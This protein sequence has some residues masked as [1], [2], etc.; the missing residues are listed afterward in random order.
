MLF[1]LAYLSIFV[2]GTVGNLLVVWVV[3]SC[4]VSCHRIVKNPSILKIVQKMQTVTNG[5]ILESF[6]YSF[7][8]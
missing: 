1:L 4:K 2:V 3:L 5:T 7:A 6:H 8:P